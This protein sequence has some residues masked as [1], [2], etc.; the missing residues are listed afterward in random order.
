MK[1]LEIMLKIESLVNKK[2]NNRK[3]L[4][5]DIGKGNQFENVY[6]VWFKKH[7]CEFYWYS[8][9]FKK[10]EIKIL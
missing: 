7:Q 2:E 1:L 3:V 4:I 5:G 6:K 10:E 8:V 9:T